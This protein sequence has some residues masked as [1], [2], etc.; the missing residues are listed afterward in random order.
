MVS[1]N[2]WVMYAGVS[3]LPWGGVG[4]SGFGRIHGPDGLLEFARSKSTVR[5]R[6]ALPVPLISFARHPRTTEVVR[7][8][9]SVVHGR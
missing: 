6:F 1:M 8:I 7:K 2:S 5:E 4:Q 9:T 3:A